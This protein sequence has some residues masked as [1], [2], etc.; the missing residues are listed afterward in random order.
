MEGWQGGFLYLEGRNKVEIK[1]KYGLAFLGKAAV[2]LFDDIGKIF[3]NTSAAAVFGFAA[4]AAGHVKV[5]E[6]DRLV[7]FAVKIILYSFIVKITTEASNHP[8]SVLSVFALIRHI[9]TKSGVR[10]QEKQD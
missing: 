9:V 5:F 1:Q 8:C 4:V 3:A 6:M 2:M 7:F 10:L